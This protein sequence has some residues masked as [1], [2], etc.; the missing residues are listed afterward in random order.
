[1]PGLVLLYNHRGGEKS[2]KRKEI[3]IMMQYGYW[4]AHEAEWE[5]M[6]EMAEWLAFEADMATNPYKE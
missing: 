4:E 2:P 5:A 6:Q 3:K 1:M